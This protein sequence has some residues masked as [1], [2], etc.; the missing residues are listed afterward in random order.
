MYVF[1]HHSKDKCCKSFTLMD[2]QTPQLP[3]YE[4]VLKKTVKKLESAMSYK[5]AMEGVLYDDQCQARSMQFLR[6]VIVWLLRLMSPNYPKE[7]VK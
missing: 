1:S 2:F 6:Y 4:A 5:M 3:V 7:P